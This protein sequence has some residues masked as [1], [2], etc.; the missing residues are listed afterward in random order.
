MSSLKL[1]TSILLLVLLCTGIASPVNA[2]DPP[3]P[4]AGKSV[5]K[6]VTSFEFPALR[7]SA[8]KG[9]RFVQIQ[10][11]VDADCNLVEKGRR[12]LI[13]VPDDYLQQKPPKFTV[14]VGEDNDDLATDPNDTDAFGTLSTARVSIWETDV[15][16]IHTVQL[17][18]TQ[19]WRWDRVSTRL[20]K[21]NANA[22][23][24]CAWWHISDGPAYSRGR[25]NPQRIWG[26][27]SP[28]FLY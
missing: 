3:V 9:P 1:L 26:K 17:D 16:G 8:A 10:Y 22:G 24:C 25:P 4:Q 7:V 5:C 11:E 6:K 19:K 28:V 13:N 15:V 14:S 18:L 21:G 27:G 23:M 20:K 2:A 12:V